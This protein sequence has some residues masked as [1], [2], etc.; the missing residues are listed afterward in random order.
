VWALRP[1]HHPKTKGQS[2]VDPF[3]RVVFVV[4]LLVCRPAPR[5]AVGS[6]MFLGRNVDQLEVEKYDGGDP[7][8]DGKLNVRIV[9]QTANVLG[10]HFDDELPDADDVKAEGTESAEKAV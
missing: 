4:A 2:V 9:E 6:V 8:V 3:F 1:S 5:Q 7:S 10:V